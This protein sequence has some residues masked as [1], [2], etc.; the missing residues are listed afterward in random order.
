MRILRGLA[1]KLTL[2]LRANQ[3][4]NH[5]SCWLL[6]K[7]RYIS[8]YV[9]RETT[10]QGSSR[11]AIFESNVQVTSKRVRVTS[12]R[13]SGVTANKRATPRIFMTS[14]E[15][16]EQHEQRVFFQVMMSRKCAIDGS[17]NSRPGDRVKRWCSRGQMEVQLSTRHLAHL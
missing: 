4:L 6:Q 11:R 14:S 5:K 17:W 8:S 3:R 16:N 7:V 9:S 10:I 2:E 1:L 12:K 15:Q 13:V